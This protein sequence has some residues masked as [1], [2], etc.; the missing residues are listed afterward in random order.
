MKALN[1]ER[2]KR[3]G[4]LKKC[5]HCKL[6]VLG[7][8]RLSLAFLVIP[9]CSTSHSFAKATRMGISKKSGACRRILRNKK[10]CKMQ[11]FHLELDSWVVPMFTWRFLSPK[12]CFCLSLIWNCLDF[13]VISSLNLTS[14]CNNMKS[15]YK[16]VKMFICQYIHCVFFLLFVCLF[17]Y[18]LS[19]NKNLIA[20]PS[21]LRS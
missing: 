4:L 19:A 3:Q 7:K 1:T 20:N 2:E 11:C 17:Q 6:L 14:P 9:R 12:Y 21:S 10:Y 13:Y 15:T 5:G 8:S 16:R 18:S